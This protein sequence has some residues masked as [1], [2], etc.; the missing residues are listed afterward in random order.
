M[1]ACELCNGT[2]TVLLIV[3]YADHHFGDPSPVV[4]GPLCD[5]CGDRCAEFAAREWGDTVTRHPLGDA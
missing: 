3:H 5:A 2:A 1:A 4:R